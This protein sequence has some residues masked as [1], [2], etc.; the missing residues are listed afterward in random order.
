MMGST[1][2]DDEATIALHQH[3]LPHAE[4][5]PCRHPDKRIMVAWAVR[6]LLCQVAQNHRNVVEASTRHNFLVS[7]NISF[8]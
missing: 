8:L 7:S 6:R 3:G 5:A 1:K 4:R 2:V